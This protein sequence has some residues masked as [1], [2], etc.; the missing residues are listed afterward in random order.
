MR[1]ETNIKHNLLFALQGGQ[2]VNNIKVPH[3]VALNFACVTQHRRMHRS[4][5]LEGRKNRLCFM[6]VRISLRLPSWVRCACWYGCCYLG[7]F[8]LL[9][10]AI[11]NSISWQRP[12]EIIGREEISQW[13][14]SQIEFRFACRRLWFLVRGADAILLHR[15][16]KMHALVRDGIGHLRPDSNDYWILGE[17]RGSM[18]SSIRCLY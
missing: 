10:P 4:H 18:W 1:Q 8:S 17:L 13:A 3:D 6:L 11:S 5:H 16:H 14:L 7:L 2:R 15:A 12:R 9:L